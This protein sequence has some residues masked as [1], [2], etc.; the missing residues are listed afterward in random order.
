MKSV[1]IVGAGPAGLFLAKYLSDVAKINIYEQSNNILGHYNYSLDTKK[2]NFMNI[3]QNDNVKLFLNRKIKNTAELNDDVIIL[4]TGGIQRDK[5]K[6][7]K[8]AV[9][10]IKSIFEKNPNKIG[11]NICIIGMGNVAF[12]YLTLIKDK[13]K[14]AT[15]L[16]RSNILKS[17]FDNGKL[18]DI[19]KYYNIKIINNL[20]SNNDIK[21]RI[22]KSRDNI[23]KNIKEVADKP[24]L[25]LIFE[26]N[27]KE[28]KNNSVTFETNNKIEKKVFDDVFS[29]IGFIPNDNVKVTDDKLVFKL[30][31]CKNATGDI[32]KTQI[33]ALRL[34]NHIKTII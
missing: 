16:S 30:G 3:L 6:N 15:V 33:D 24:Q 8:S 5:I 7:T 12:D 34:S 11:T 31:W 9:E 1:G 26:T 2:N 29:S 21:T 27:V 10:N 4:C 13:I 17:K 22:D 14:N 25:N 20:I 18:R 19:S 32:S 23:I 28:V